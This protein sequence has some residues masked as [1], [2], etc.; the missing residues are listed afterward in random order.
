M[1][2]ITKTFFTEYGTTANSHRMQGKNCMVLK[3][4][5]DSTASTKYKIAQWIVHIPYYVCALK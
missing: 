2:F 3:G 5:I 4:L 1:S